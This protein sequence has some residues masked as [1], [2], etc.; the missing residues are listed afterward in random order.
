MRFS[1][2][3]TGVVAAPA[4]IALQVKKPPA[5][6]LTPAGIVIRFLSSYFVLLIFALGAV[7][8]SNLLALVPHLVGVRAD[9]ACAS[10]VDVSRCCCTLLHAVRAAC[11][12]ERAGRIIP[13]PCT[14]QATFLLGNCTGASMDGRRLRA[15]TSRETLG[16]VAAG[17]HAAFRESVL[18]QHSGWRKHRKIP[19]G[20]RKE[21]RGEVVHHTSFG[22]AEDAFGGFWAPGLH[23]S[24]AKAKNNRGER[25]NRI[26]PLPYVRG[27]L[28]PPL[29]PLSSSSCVACSSQVCTS[30]AGSVD[31][32][33]ST[34]PLSSGCF[35]I[36]RTCSG[37]SSC[38]PSRL[39]VHRDL[40]H[41]TFLPTAQASSRAV[42]SPQHSFDCSEGGCCSYWLSASPSHLR[43]RSVRPVESP[44]RTDGVVAST[45]LFAHK[46]Q[47][48]GAK[49]WHRTRP[50][51][52]VPSHINTRPS[53]FSHSVLN[54]VNAPPEYL[55]A[56]VPEA[57]VVL[58]RPKIATLL[59]LLWL[60]PRQYQRGSAAFIPGPVPC[61]LPSPKR[62]FGS[63]EAPTHE[64]L[65]VEKQYAEFVARQ[66]SE[67]IDRA[68]ACAAQFDQPLVNAAAAGVDTAAGKALQ[69]IA[70]DEEL[71]ADLRRL[72]KLAD[73]KDDEA[74]RVLHEHLSVAISPARL[75]GPG[76]PPLASGPLGVSEQKHSV[77]AQQPF[78]EGAADRE[79]A[80]SSDTGEA[81]ANQEK[82]KTTKKLVWL[83]FYRQ[84]AKSRHESAASLVRDVCRSPLTRFNRLLIAEAIDRWWSAWQ[85]RRLAGVVTKKLGRL[86]C[87]GRQFKASGIP[88]EKLLE[89][90]AF[91]QYRMFDDLPHT[92]FVANYMRRHSCPWQPPPH[93]SSCGVSSD[94]EG[95]L[96]NNQ[97]W[98]G[99]QGSVGRRPGIA[100]GAASTGDENG[101]K[102][103]QTLKRA[104]FEELKAL[105]ILE[106]DGSLDLNLLKELY[107]THPAAPPRDEKTEGRRRSLPADKMS[108]HERHQQIKYRHAAVGLSL[109]AAAREVKTLEV[110]ERR[111]D[112][113]DVG[114]RI[115]RA[116]GVF[117]ALMREEFPHYEPVRDVFKLAIEIVDLHYFFV[118]AEGFLEAEYRHHTIKRELR[119]L[120][121]E[122]LRLGMPED[123]KKRKYRHT[124]NNEAKMTSWFT[125]CGCQSGREKLCCMPNNNV[126][127]PVC[128][129][130]I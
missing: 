4:C 100:D 35:R 37:F 106:S 32:D 80:V 69:A 68:T 103:R 3:A 109:P 105:G 76:A 57:E 72:K 11:R 54:F 62:V 102:R 119:K 26:C 49:K 1:A 92:R 117:D 6:I 2:I 65:R 52:T 53:V 20:L 95:A 130:H 30:S 10:G 94:K 28:L 70:Y 60:L 21:P 22:N 71:G 63:F 46:K 110:W 89:E 104:A 127:P 115:A 33:P 66:E 86:K 36:S 85:D 56:P 77:T 27:F 108:R 82:A 50:K 7:P 12:A 78:A 93:S 111:E 114:G 44:R 16:S 64:Q 38:S 13:G 125:G 5:R 67:I 43:V 121:L 90:N 18:V 99:Y 19:C 29:V 126:L 91:E 73:E 14:T 55:P 51:K 59:R 31:A 9:S 128:Q 118:G 42:R 123:A 25:P 45:R 58:N 79:A 83:P 122:W 8:F 97:P 84:R 113:E 61:P 48:K 47:N 75:P 88:P 81:I 15:V 41:P 112:S 98:I 120:Y 96:T 40:S 39:S 24:V 23:F 74:L 101:Q 34:E 17:D 124:V 107:R 129:T 87:L 116:T